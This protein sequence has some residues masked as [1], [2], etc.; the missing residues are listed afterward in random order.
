MTTWRTYILA[1]LV[2]GA[3]SC[4]ADSAPIRALTTAEYRSEI[5]GLLAATQSLDSAVSEIPPVFQTL[6]Q[7]WSIHSDAG[8]FEISTEGLRRDI[9][10]YKD[11]QNVTNATAIRT[12]L[13]TLRRDID[14][15][16]QAPSDVSARRAEL[17]AILAR[18]EFSD[19]HGP[20]WSDR[21]KR[22]ILEKL[23]YLFSRIFRSSAIPTV[24]KYF[25]YAL[26]G[27][28]GLALLYLVYRS[29]LRDREFEEVVPK[30]LPVSAKEWT[31]WLSEARAAATRSDWREAVHLAYWA[32]IS[33][34]EQ[35]GFWKP[36]RA[37]TPREYLRLISS[38][39]EERETLTVLTRVFELAWYAKR[40]ASEATYSQTLEQLEKLGCR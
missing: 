37:R 6:P 10:R 8:D 11:E 31:I 38:Q 24:G 22:W 27:L 39:S 9:R 29:I 1:L 15:F 40:D 4:H 35:Q 25:V 7:S 13:E 28:A 20:N 16:E 18:P 12:R 30:D 2:L 34:L 32:G 3:V 23:I 5:D 33:Y 26:I 36:D 14:G 21:L 19:V 17:N